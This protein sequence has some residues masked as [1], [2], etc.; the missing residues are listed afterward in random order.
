VRIERDVPIPMADGVV[1]RA[2]VFRPD[3]DGRHPII[4]SHGPYAKDLSFQQGFPGRW[5]AMVEQF[6]EIE[7][8]SSN[9]HQ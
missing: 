1:L 9:E 3:D 6:P 7:A 8:G 5:A 4:M 2:D